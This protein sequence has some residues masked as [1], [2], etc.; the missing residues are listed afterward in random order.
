MSD[1]ATDETGNGLPGSG[2][3]GY[4]VASERV[5]CYLWWCVFAVRKHSYSSTVQPLNRVVVVDELEIVKMSGK[6]QLVV[7][8][9]VRTKA[10][11]APGERFVAFP[12]RGGVFFKKIEAPTIRLDF[13]ELAREIEERFKESGVKRTDVNEAVRWARRR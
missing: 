8:R 5:T 13:D 9:D 6:G 7:P 2:G 10:Q 1:R 11:L 4:D 12:V 3:N